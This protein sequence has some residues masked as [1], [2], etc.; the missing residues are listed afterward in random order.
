MHNWPIKQLDV[1]NVFLNGIL[2]EE[3]YM[4][5]PPTFKD[6]TRPDHVCQHHMALYGL[7]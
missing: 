4:L 6:S 5:Q 1:K 7:K 2:K 3:V